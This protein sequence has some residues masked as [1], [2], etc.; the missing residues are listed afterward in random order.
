MLHEHQ[1]EIG[2]MFHHSL[3]AARSDGASYFLFPIN[4]Q[5]GL[6]SFGLL[7]ELPLTHRLNFSY[8]V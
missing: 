7:Q 8:G 6:S 5:V 2:C 3:R 4:V 1:E